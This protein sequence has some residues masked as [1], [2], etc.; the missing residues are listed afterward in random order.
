MSYR[1]KLSPTHSTIT[2]VTTLRIAV[3]SG[4]FSIV[5]G[6]MS[7]IA[8]AA[9]TYNN[10]IEDVLVVADMKRLLTE[11]RGQYND[12]MSALGKAYLTL[13]ESESEFPDIIPQLTKD[14]AK[15]VSAAYAAFKPIMRPPRDLLKE[16]LDSRK[17]SSDLLLDTL[18][19]KS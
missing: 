15:V 3:G 16:E 11:T 5:A 17:A 2:D 6:A 12:G 18:A 1:I 4:F 8:E 9:N 19:R 13:R 10:G 7:R 14:I